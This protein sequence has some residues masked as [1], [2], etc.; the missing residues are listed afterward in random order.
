MKKFCLSLILF[1]LFCVTAGA[2]QSGEKRYDLYGVGFYNLENLFDT[3]HDAGKNDYE[4][5]PGGSYHWNSM[6]YNS[7]LQH[8]AKVLSQLCTDKLPVGAS[9]IGVS[10]VENARCMADLVAQKPL[11]DRGYK[12]VH[13]DGPDRR[14]V[15]CAF[16]YNPRFF[17]LQDYYLVPFYYK[18]A[19]QPDV[20]LGFTVGADNKVKPYPIHPMR[21]DTA[22]ITRG[23]LVMTGLLGG[24]KIHFIVCHLPSRAAAS[25]ARERGGEQLYALKNALLKQDPGSKVIIMGDMNDD[26]KNKSMSEAL[27]CKHKKADV[28]DAADMYNPWWDVLYK[29]GQGTLLYDGKWN[30]FDQ[31]LLSGGFVGDDRSTLKLFQNRIFLKDYLIQQE[32]KYKGSPL[33]THASGVWLNGYSDHLPT[34]VYLIKEKK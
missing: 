31:I 34:Y 3:I 27:A 20:D 26:P 9:V 18:D 14:G 22:Y 16:I 19:A 21:G 12:Y 4:F 7:K 32:G 24:E 30:L 2:Q 10:E 23:F 8:M 28:K 13:V 29:V 11:A 1:V 6:K 15:D 25:P 33:R 17:T 5:L